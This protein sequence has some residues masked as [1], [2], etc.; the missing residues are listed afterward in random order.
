MSFFLKL[1]MEIFIIYNLN[2]SIIYFSRRAEAGRVF[3]IVVGKEL[4]LSQ[5][6]NLKRAN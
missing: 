4:K 6:S 1:F 5:I 2:N 3:S